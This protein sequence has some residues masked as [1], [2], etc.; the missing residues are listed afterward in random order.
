MFYFWGKRSG[1]SGNP[2]TVTLP[3]ATD[4]ADCAQACS[5]WDNARQSLCGAKSDEAAARARAD[6]IRGQLLAVVAAEATAIGVAV[7][8]TVAAIAAGAP[9][10][11]VILAVVAVILWAA[12]ATLA[13]VVAFLGGQLNAAE[14]DL[15]TKASARQAWDNA[16]ANARAEVNS[17]CS[18]AEANACLSRTA[19]C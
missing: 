14:I 5:T 4:T 11:V 16:V 7:T 18:Q 12:V 15:A 1:G 8:A 3:G 10:V 6:G 2:P 17:K 19:P 9:W 13:A